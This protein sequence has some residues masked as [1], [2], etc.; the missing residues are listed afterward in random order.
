MR[1]RLGSLMAAV[2]PYA[3][4]AV[5]VSAASATQLAYLS[6]FPW[7]DLF[8]NDLQLHSS[9]RWFA[10]SMSA[11][12][13]AETVRSIFDFRVNVGDNVAAS[14]KT[15]SPIFDLGAWLTWATGSQYVAFSL[16][17]LAY[18]LTAATGLA[19]LID[20]NPN[21]GRRAAGIV[22]FTV[23]LASMSL[24]PNLHHEVG[25]LNQWFMLTVPAWCWLLGDGLVLLQRRPAL[26]IAALTG[27]IVLSLGST[28]LFLAFHLST[29]FG[30]FLLRSLVSRD[31]TVA[32]LS[33]AS[34]VAAF[35]LV[36]KSDFLLAHLRGGDPYVVSTSASWTLAQYVE[37]YLWPTLSKS[38][39]KPEFH[40]PITVFLN[41]PT[42]LLLLTSLGLSKTFRSVGVVGSLLVTVVCLISLGAALHYFDST[43]ALLPSVVRYHL[44]IVPFVVAS[45][46][47]RF[48]S[49]STAIHRRPVTPAQAIPLA[50]LGLGVAVLSSTAYAGSVP[51]SSRHVISLGL[52]QWLTEGLPGCV[53]AGVG[54]PSL[55]AEPR[56]FVFVGAEWS[57]RS[58]RNDTLLFLIEQPEALGGRTF[59]QWRYSSAHYNDVLLKAVGQSSTNGWPFSIRDLADA[60]RLS[61][62]SE[63]PFFVSTVPIGE[64]GFVE[65]AKCPFPTQL[66][67]ATRGNPT[68]ASTVWVYHRRRSVPS[69]I[70][71]IDYQSTKVTA[72]VACPTGAGSGDVGLP[73]GFH[74]SLYIT[75]PVS[76]AAL[77]SGLDGGVVVQLSP[78]ACAADGTASVTIRSAARG[79]VWRLVLLAILP[80]L[81]VGLII[82]NR[83][84][85]DNQ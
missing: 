77:R 53:A 78:A 24:H 48:G 32:L 5:A 29:L 64:P 51:E 43:R 35:V 22:V 71:H 75:H 68:L 74:P 40:G 67:D 28:D 47:A 9:W 25:P 12:G 55:E 58:G 41:A 19:L 26:Y 4:G 39:L 30:F 45:L 7:Q 46:L 52:N 49:L 2:G 33:V 23:L 83:R 85:S 15:P 79:R 84:Q 80:V 21:L 37:V 61:D 59:N 44:G 54:R 50:A 13:F 34:Y 3:V 57:S 1:Q 69:T 38:L 11:G 82:A 56:S 63:S 8:W 76:G 62:S 70:R 18:V 66:S 6:R 60:Q 14:L 31:D 20:A 36:E 16:K 72:L 27:V 65:L 42:L 17:F 10:E 81:A 73:I